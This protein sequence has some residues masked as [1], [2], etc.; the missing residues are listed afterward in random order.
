MHAPRGKAYVSTEPASY[1]GT[2]IGS[3]LLV[4]TGL[5]VAL[6]WA[7]ASVIRR[8]FRTMW[9]LLGIGFVALGALMWARA[10]TSFLVT[11][12]VLGLGVGCLV[13][14]LRRP[15]ARSATIV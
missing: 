8:E 9:A 4:S 1:F 11:A 7:I 15:H 2:M 5:G 3:A 12:I 14:A 10:W 6:M 13:Q